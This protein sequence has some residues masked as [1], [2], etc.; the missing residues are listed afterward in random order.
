MSHQ[1]NYYEGDSPDVTAQL[2]MEANGLTNDP[3][4][5]SLVQQLTNLIRQNINDIVQARTAAANA[6][7]KPIFN[8]PVNLGG[9]DFE[10]P[11]FANQD[12]A[13]VATN[14]CDTQMPAISAN[15]G[16]EA[17]P[18]ELQ[19]CKVFLFQTITGILD[20]AQK[21]NEAE[22]QPKEP[23]LLFTLDIDLG[24]GKNAALPFYEGE[25]DEAVA[26]SFCQKYNVDVENVPFLV[27]EIR[28]QIANL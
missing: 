6:D 28:R 19:Q 14:F 17:A 8:V 7:A 5:A 24:D 25:N 3:N 1:L 12:P 2:F 4:Y 23:A 9:T 18:E 11:Y 16:R 27:E 15:M 21:P 26:H 20:K 22:T 13:V 10:I